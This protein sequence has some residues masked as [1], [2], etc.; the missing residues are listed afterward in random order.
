MLHLHPFMD[1]GDQI[2]V[3]VTITV[4]GDVKKKKMEPSCHLA[5]AKNGLLW[6]EYS[7][8]IN[9]SGPVTV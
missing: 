1:F 5:T 4:F 3:S 8:E 2:I 7:A 6:L 9:N